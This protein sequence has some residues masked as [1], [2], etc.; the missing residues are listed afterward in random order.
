LIGEMKSVPKSYDGQHLN[1][2][3]NI[4]NAQKMGKE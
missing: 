1:E 2:P 3:L 4:E